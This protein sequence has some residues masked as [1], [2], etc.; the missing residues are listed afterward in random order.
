[1]ASWIIE[2]LIFT[3]ILIVATN[4][5]P[6]CAGVDIAINGIT[7]DHIIVR[8]ISDFLSLTCTAVNNT[9]DEE[10]VW[11]RGDRVINLKSM[12]RI[13]VSTVCIDP[14]TENDNEAKFS[15]HLNK[16][17]NINTA[18][19]LDIKFIPVLSSD[20]DGQI[21][22]YAGN[23]VKL[24]CNVKSNPP[25]VM[26]WHKD[27][28]ALKMVMGKHSVYWDSGVF[29]LSIKKV[30]NTENG[31]YICM[32]DSTLGSNNLTFYLNVKDQPY[33]VPFEPIVAG[34]TVVVL[35]IFFGIVSRRKLIIQ[36][37]KKKTHSDRYTE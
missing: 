19:R 15:C 31:T 3:L 21:D 28:S 10:L 36:Y 11:F 37:F 2:N 22:V 27:N 12:N 26:S 9:Q 30:Q 6:G 34:L 33:V 17:H 32:A 20:S 14:I 13:N 5:V 25:A 24:Q 18:V 7:T 23:D 35:T 29:S 4:F 8:N 16:N 1:M